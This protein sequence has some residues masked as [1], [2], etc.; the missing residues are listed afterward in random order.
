MIVSPRGHRR[1]AQQYLPLGMPIQDSWT[2]AS[3]VLAEDELLVV[4]SDGVFD[5]FDDSFELAAAQLPAI[6]DPALSCRQI[7]DRIVEF[8]VGQGATDDVTAVV[9]RRMGGSAVE[10]ATA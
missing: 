3:D 7:V 10:T 1:L 5:V 8:A 4:V 9:L 6:Q 2:S